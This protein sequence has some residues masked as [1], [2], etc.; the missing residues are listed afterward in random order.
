MACGKIVGKGGVGGDDGAL[1]N[2]GPDARAV[3]SPNDV[4]VGFARRRW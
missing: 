1:L 3:L 2:G 4:T